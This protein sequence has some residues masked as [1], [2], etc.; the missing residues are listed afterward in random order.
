MQASQSWRPCTF[1]AWLSRSSSRLSTTSALRPQEGNITGSQNS[2]RQRFR[3]F[4]AILLVW[5]HLFDSRHLAYQLTKL[6]RLALCNWM[7]GISCRC[8]FYGR[9]H[10]PGLDR[11][12]RRDVRAAKLACHLAHD[13]GH[14]ILNHIQYLSRRSAPSHRRHRTS[15]TSVWHLRHH[16]PTLGNGSAGPCTCRTARL[17]KQRWLADK[18]T[19]GDDRVGDS[20]KCIDRI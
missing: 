16:H 8:V 5:I 18:G 9:R 3:S 20:T 1:H 12:E 4:S 13:C 10:H 15:L 19:L 14:L 17:P 6:H 11:V 7:A 2:L